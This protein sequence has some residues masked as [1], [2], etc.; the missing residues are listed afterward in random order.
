MQSTS[1]SWILHCSWSLQWSFEL[2]VSHSA[3]FVW[4][5]WHPF[6][7]VF[8]FSVTTIFPRSQIQPLVP[9][10]SFT[11]LLSILTWNHK[12]RFFFLLWNHW[13]KDSVLCVVYRMAQLE[14]D[15]QCLNRWYC[16]SSQSSCWCLFWAH[17][18]WRNHTE[19]IIEPF[20][21]QQFLHL[22]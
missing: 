5:L 6:V 18:S 7:L 17:R 14:T 13:W 16:S 10:L 4:F 12:V 2:S 9:C 1:L 19:L 3:S 15:T 21:F 11:L 20:S 22:F 8:L